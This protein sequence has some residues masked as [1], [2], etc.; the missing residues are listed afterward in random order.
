M[1]IGTGTYL[2][3]PKFVVTRAYIGAIAFP[4]E[5][6]LET[7]S[8]GLYV[9]NDFSLYNDRLFV[10]I[11]Y[12]FFLW[13]SNHYTLDFIVEECFFHALPSTVE[14]PLNFHLSYLPGDGTWPATIFVRLAPFSN[15]PARV[16]LPL[17][18]G[19]YWRPLT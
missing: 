13:T 15:T 9:L 17:V 6:T 18:S 10:K 12:P 7:A 1:T 4:S 19:T 14:H 16:A 8:S 11:Q 5:L 2:Q 3:Y